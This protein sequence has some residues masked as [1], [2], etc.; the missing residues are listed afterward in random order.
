MNNEK[1]RYGE[2]MS[3]IKMIYVR[4]PNIYPYNTCRNN[5]YC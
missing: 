2:K 3:S 5:N 4:N 1:G